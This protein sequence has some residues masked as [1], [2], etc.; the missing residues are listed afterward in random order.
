MTIHRFVASCLLAGAVSL[1]G[2]ASAQKPNVILILADDLGWTDLASYGSHL[3]ETPALDQ[4]ARDGMKFTRITSS[5]APGRI[6]PEHSDPALRAGRPRSR[7]NLRRLRG[8]TGDPNPFWIRHSFVGGL[9]SSRA[10]VC[11]A[12]ATPSQNRIPLSR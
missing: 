4:L 6:A 2:A 5:V 9:S 3:V 1:A 8:G 7:E 11:M 10:V 12:F